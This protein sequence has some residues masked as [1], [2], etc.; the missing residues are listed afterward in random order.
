MRIH[1]QYNKPNHGDDPEN[2]YDC[3][4]CLYAPTAN[5]HILLL[6][7]HDGLVQHKLCLPCAVEGLIITATGVDK[8]TLMGETGALDEATRDMIA[9]RPPPPWK[10]Y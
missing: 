1:I 2:R 6:I 3:D 8:E 10:G 5:E 9:N 7:N 4:Q